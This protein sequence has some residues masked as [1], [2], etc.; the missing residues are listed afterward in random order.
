[1]CCVCAVRCTCVRWCGRSCPW[2]I[3]RNCLEVIERERNIDGISL[4][5]SLSLRLLFSIP[6]YLRWF[7]VRW[8]AVFFILLLLSSLIFASFSGISSS[9]ASW[10]LSS[11]VVFISTP[12]P[13]PPSSPPGPAPLH[14]FRNE[15][16]TRKQRW[17]NAF[18][19]HFSSF[20]RH[21]FSGAAGAAA[22]FFSFRMT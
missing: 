16:N 20:C 6:Y 18:G 4:Y 11:L 19:F 7:F 13:S 3:K 21:F 8:L 1:M 15:T 12:L 5:L 22:A 14:H 10:L 17:E 2:N 9:I